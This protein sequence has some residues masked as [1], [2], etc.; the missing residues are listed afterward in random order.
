[1]EKSKAFP[2]IRTTEHQFYQYGWYYHF[3]HAAQR[4]WAHG[5][6]HHY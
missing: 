5:K 1:M 6:T 3:K 2:R 4:S